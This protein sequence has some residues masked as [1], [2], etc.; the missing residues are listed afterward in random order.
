MDGVEPCWFRSITSYH[1]LTRVAETSS[2]NE[3]ISPCYSS[4]TELKQ[5]CFGAGTFLGADGSVVLPPSL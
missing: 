4:I 2:W 3:S 5:Y 1:N